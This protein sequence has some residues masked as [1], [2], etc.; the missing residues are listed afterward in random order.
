M[1]LL[2][3]LTILVVKV[4]NSSTNDRVAGGEKQRVC[5]AR[6]LIKNPRVLVLDEATASLDAES[7]AAIADT[8]GKATV[9]RSVLVIAH[10]LRTVQDAHSIVVLKHGKVVEIGNHQELIAKNGHYASLVNKQYIEK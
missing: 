7:E 9:G 8:L 2:A 5:L 1:G 4:L 10:R 6:A 3:S